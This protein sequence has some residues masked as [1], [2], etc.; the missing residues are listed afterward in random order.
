MIWTARALAESG[1]ALALPGEL[2]PA[3]CRGDISLSRL[4]LRFE[5]AQTIFSSC[6]LGGGHQLCSSFLN[7][8]LPPTDPLGERDPA[9]YLQQK[10]QEQ[11]LSQPCAAMMTAASM[12]SF[13]LAAARFEQGTIAVML[14]AGLANARRAGDRAEYRQFHD[15]PEEQ[16]TINSLLV[17]DLPMQ[18]AAMV[19][20][21]MMLTEAKVAV[22]QDLG[23]ASPVSGGLATGT[24]TD[25]V[26]VISPPLHSQQQSLRFVG[27]H[28]LFGEVSARLYQ[29]ALKSALQYDKSLNRKTQIGG[30]G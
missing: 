27:K 3:A 18:G 16:G 13:R 28:T 24:G 2:L 8:Q 11:G 21:V 17:T 20:A 1:A 5:S 15:E 6:V 10:S 30:D 12:R 29:E 23:C 14:T 26:A 7:W 25:S 4:V 9:D 19:E 22:L